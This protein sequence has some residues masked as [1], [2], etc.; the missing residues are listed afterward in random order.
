MK[1]VYLLLTILGLVVPYYFFITFLLEFGL[2]FELFFQQLFATPISTFFAVD[3]IITAIV[4]L[5]YSRNES[6]RLGVGNWR[7]YLVTT[8]LVGPSFSFP[9]FQY[10]RQKKIE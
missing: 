7:V 9:L 8:L 2:D 6:K 1:R 10:V 3:L 4:F 5:Y